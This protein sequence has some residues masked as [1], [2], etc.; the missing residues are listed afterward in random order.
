MTARQARKERITQERREQIL[1][2]A[3]S[4]FSTR[5]YGES[6]MADVAEAAGVGV[7]TI[8]NYYKDKRDLLISLVQNLLISENLV[9]ILDKMTLYSSRDFMDLLIEE[10]L[11]FGFDNAQTILFLM[12][13]IQRDAKMRRK[14]VQNVVWPLLSRL[15]NL[16]RSQV[17]SGV[18]RK[19][20]EKIIARAMAGTIIGNA[21]LFRLEQRE[22][23]LK[24]AHLKDIAHELSG[25]FIDGL[26]GK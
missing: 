14:Y 1:K 17:K 12:F 11:R 23:P 22:S 6:T 10:R 3:L 8:Y 16:I 5:G 7:G 4:V 19:V 20:D 15:E 21:L 18:F 9:S 25:L 2:A 24:K 13:E 26:A